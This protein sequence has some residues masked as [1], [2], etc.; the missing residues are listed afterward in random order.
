[1]SRQ[2]GL[3]DVSFAKML[4]DVLAG[5]TYDTVKKYERTLSAKITPKS[6]TET[7]YSDDNVEDIVSQF[8][9]VDVE[10]ELN[11]LS[12]ETRAFLQGS[13]VVNGILIENKDDIAPYVYM[14]FRSKKA[15]GKYRYVA[16]FKGKFELTADNFETQ[17]DKVKSQTATIK[18]TF[19]ARDFD[20]NWRLIGDEDANV[21]DVTAL[22]S[23][24]TTVPT[25]PVAQP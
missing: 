11:Q 21:T 19:M 9:S 7:E 15:N 24:L 4:T 8:T 16:L 13:K 23:W 25:I 10:I 2:I 1:M 12:L 17:A 3:K 6:D 14:A 22:A 20:G 18:G 5:A